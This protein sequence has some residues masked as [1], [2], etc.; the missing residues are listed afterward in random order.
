MSKKKEAIQDQAVAALGG[1]VGGGLGALAGPETI[2][3]GGAAGSVGALLVSKYAP[4]YFE[5]SILHR[6]LSNRKVVAILKAKIEA[7]LKNSFLGSQGDFDQAMTSMRSLLQAA[8]SQDR[9]IGTL[10]SRLPRSFRWSLAKTDADNEAF[11]HHVS[12]VATYC[13]QNGPV[14]IGCSAICAAA[15]ATLRDLHERFSNSVGVRFD[16]SCDEINGRTFFD[17]L[18]ANCDLDF[19]IGPLEALVLSDEGH[20]LPLRLVGP[21]CG[22]RQHVYVSTKKMAGFR[23][24]VWVFDRSSAKFQYHVGLGIPRSAEERCFDDARDVPDLV[25]SIPPG[26]M[27]IAW[28]PLSSVLT[29]RKDYAIVHNSEYTVHFILLGHLRVFRKNQFPLHDF[30]A[31]LLTEWRRRQHHHTILFEVLRRDQRFMAA[32]ALGAGHHWT[33]EV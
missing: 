17:S 28:D 23:S 15:V 4:A 30:L 31:V 24:G 16:V 18:R 7:D 12:Q 27:V 3:V 21:L 1:L 22:E 5:K 10:E 26:D 20:K 2:A 6:Y 8:N 19:A 9:S 13:A 14:R 11:R 29:R 32:F 33:P 25:E